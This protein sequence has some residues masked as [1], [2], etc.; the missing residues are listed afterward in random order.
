MTSL[1][2]RL[3]DGT[4]GLVIE[5]LRGSDEV[6]ERS[7]QLTALAAPST[8][9][10]CRWPWVSASLARGPAAHP[11]AVTVMDGTSL[12]AAA[13]L[14]DVDEVGQRIT[15]LAGTAEGHRGALL[16]H[17]P[18]AARALGVGLAAA[19]QAESRAFVLGPVAQ[20]EALS[21]L[22]RC[23]PE[24]VAVEPVAI[25]LL[26]PRQD[27][28]GELS[29]AM[30][31]TLRKARNRLATDSVLVDMDVLDDGQSVAAALPLILTIA[32]HRDRTCGRKSPLD[33]PW[34]RRLWQNRLLALNS[35]GTLRLLT[36]R[37]DDEVA[38]YALCILDGRTLRVL[39]GRYVE[40]FNRY[41]PGR[42]LEAAVL[43]R[44]RGSA[45]LD[46]V[47]W[48]TTVGPESLLAANGSDP[49]VLLRSPARR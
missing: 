43:E 29:K 40:R 9:A 22:L 3:H 37:L 5:V 35:E 44:V 45:R 4:A 8:V 34:L 18:E 26:R 19:L 6:Q 46:Q 38:A 16:A 30:R 2:I 14:L 1:D 20:G 48:M 15:T 24:D 7:S 11:W 42:L 36:L 39:D 12:V 41:A 47:D 33:D 10:T 31:R 32:R 21:T 17:D 28:E 25:P 23:L 49:Y 13:V 27:V